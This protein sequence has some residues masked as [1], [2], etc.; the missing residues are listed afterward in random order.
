MPL[1]GTRFDQSS[2]QISR[3]RRFGPPFRRALNTPMRAELGIFLL[4]SPQGT[5]PQN[6]ST[7][8]NMDQHEDIFSTVAHTLMY[9]CTHSNILFHALY[10]GARTIYWS[11]QALGKQKY[12]MRLKIRYF[13]L[14][15]RLSPSISRKKYLISNLIIFLRFPY[16]CVR[17][18]TV[19]AT[20]C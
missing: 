15:I 18:Y 9:C 6:G 11:M 19:R 20:V 16:A 4:K 3:N 17:Q 5:P 14:E 7:S 1:I 13:F 2:K 8:I 10:N 12:I